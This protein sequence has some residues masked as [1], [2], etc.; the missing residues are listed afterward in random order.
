VS[1]LHA[2]AIRRL[3]DALHATMSP[4]EAAT[5]TASV[6]AFHKKSRPADAAAHPHLTLVNPAPKPPAVVVQ[7][8]SVARGNSRRSTKKAAPQTRPL[9][10]TVT[11]LPRR[12]ATVVALAR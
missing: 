1:Q 8:P 5:A 12:A 6:L 10:A 2:R 7:H 11:R 9:V 3:K 4:A